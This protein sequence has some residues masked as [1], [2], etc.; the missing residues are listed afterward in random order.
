MRHT[1]YDSEY[2][3]ASQM[4]DS[5]R[6]D[7]F[8]TRCFE[9]DEVWFLMQDS[10]PLEREFE[11]KLTLPVWPYA[12]FAGDAVDSLAAGEPGSTSL[13]HF[14]YQMLDELMRRNVWIEVMPRDKAAGCLITPQ[15][16]FTIFEGLI[17]AGEYRF[18]S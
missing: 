17:D 10:G 7:Y 14:L 9:T 15:R 1:P 16:L 4:S 12:R 8:L 18:D 5:E 13:E 11:G 3:A 2:R 6:L